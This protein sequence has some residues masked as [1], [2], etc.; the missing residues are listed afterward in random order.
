MFLTDYVS[1]IFL[2]WEFWTHILT[3]TWKMHF[4]G[5]LA[6]KW[7]FWVP[8]ISKKEHTN[9]NM[10]LFLKKIASLFGIFEVSLRFLVFWGFRLFRAILGPFW[11][12]FGPFW[13][14]PLLSTLE[15]IWFYIIL[16]DSDAK[17]CEYRAIFAT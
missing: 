15:K 8:K 4:L 17:T 7:G 12:H 1:K 14:L 13:A 2:F 5:F 11:G 10:G 6:Q 9:P 16:T 3:I